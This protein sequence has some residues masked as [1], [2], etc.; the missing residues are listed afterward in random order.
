MSNTSSIKQ[1]AGLVIA[2]I[3]VVGGLFLPGTGDLTHEGILGLAILLATVA[4]W[5]CES[6][7]MGVAGLL[8]LVVAPIVGIAEINTV[9]SGFGTTTVIFAMAVFSLTAIVMKSDLAIRLTGFL[10]RIAGRDSRK[11]VL[12]FMVAGGLL[13]A[14][15]N[16]SATL[17]LFLGF[18]DTV[19]E[20][21]GHVK[22]KS[23]LAKCLYLGSA[24]P[25]SWEE[26]QR[27]RVRPSMCLRS[28]W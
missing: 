19:L 23:N 16:D 18:A 17:V 10:V 21:A 28:V 1:I 11:L 20:N 25:S 15:M 12:A 9:F 6:I 13:S 4:L 7:P 8:A 5:I 14:V 2:A 3:L 26:W 27:L 22:G 24:S